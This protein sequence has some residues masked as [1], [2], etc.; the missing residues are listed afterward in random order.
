MAERL[1]PEPIYEAHCTAH[2]YYEPHLVLLKTH[3]PWEP[4]SVIEIHLNRMM[5]RI[6]HGSLCVACVL[7]GHVHCTCV[8]NL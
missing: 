2:T 6:A 5:I 4:S 8:D 1:C 7:T 3:V